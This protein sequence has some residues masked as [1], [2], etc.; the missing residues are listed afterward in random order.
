MPVSVPQPNLDF[1]ATEESYITGAVVEGQSAEVEV[2]LRNL[3]FEFDQAERVFEEKEKQL[4]KA[5][6]NL[7]DQEHS[8]QPTVYKNMFIDLDNQMEDLARERKAMEDSYV[9]K[10]SILK[11]TPST[12]NLSIAGSPSSPRSPRRKS[13][14]TSHVLAHVA[15]TS[16]SL[17]LILTLLL[18]T[19]LSTFAQCESQSL[20]IDITFNIPCTLSSTFYTP[21]YISSNL[22]FLPTFRTINS[23]TSS[24]CPSTL[25]QCS[26]T[27]PYNCCTSTPTVIPST[28]LLNPP[29][30]VL[31]LND[32]YSNTGS[33]HSLIPLN[34]GRASKYSTLNYNNSYDLQPFPPPPSGYKPSDFVADDV[35][36]GNT[37]GGIQC[38]PLGFVVG[39]PDV[40]EPRYMIEEDSQSR[41]IFEELRIAC[42]NYMGGGSGSI[43]PPPLNSSPTFSCTDAETRLW[44]QGQG[45]RNSIT[46][47]PPQLGFP[48]TRESNEG[49]MMG[50][51]KESVNSVDDYLNIDDSLFSRLDSL[52]V[53]WSGKVFYGWIRGESWY[54]SS[55]L[56]ASVNGVYVEGK[57]VQEKCGEGEC[58][59]EVEEEGEVGFSTVWERSFANV[60]NPEASLPFSAT[61]C[62]YTFGGPPSPGCAFTDPPNSSNYIYSPGFSQNRAT[63][64]LGYLAQTYIRG[65]IGNS[66]S[67]LCMDAISSLPCD[68]TTY[69][70]PCLGSSAVAP[71]KVRPRKG[72]SE[73]DSPFCKCSSSSEE[74]HRT[75]PTTYYASTSTPSIP[76]DEIFSVFS[77]TSNP[78]FEEK[79]TDGGC[80]KAEGGEDLWQLGKVFGECDGGTET[81]VVYGCRQAVISTTEEDEDGQCLPPLTDWEFDVRVCNPDLD[82]TC[83]VDEDDGECWEVKFNDVCL[84]SSKEL[85]DEEI[86]PSFFTRDDWESAGF[87]CQ[88]LLWESLPNSVCPFEC[89]GDGCPSG[90]DGQQAGVSAFYVDGIWTC[91]SNNPQKVENSSNGGTQAFSTQCL[92]KGPPNTVSVQGKCVPPPTPDTPTCTTVLYPDSASPPE[93]C[94]LSNGPP[95]FQQRNL[96]D[97]IDMSVCSYDQIREY[98]PGNF[99]GCVKNEGSTSL[100]SFWTCSVNS[101]ATPSGGD[102]STILTM[103]PFFVNRIKLLSAGYNEIDPSTWLIAVQAL[104]CMQGFVDGTFGEVLRSDLPNH[105]ADVRT[106]TCVPITPSVSACDPSA[107]DSEPN[108]CKPSPASLGCGS[109]LK[110]GLTQTVLESEQSKFQGELRPVKIS[111]AQEFV[112]NTDPF[113]FNRAYEEG[114]APVPL[115]TAMVK[116]YCAGNDEITRAGPSDVAL[117]TRIF[118]SESQKDLFC[119]DGA[120][121]SDTVE[122][123]ALNGSNSSC[124]Y[125]AFVSAGNNLTSSSKGSD[126]R[127]RLGVIDSLAEMKKND[128]EELMKIHD[129]K[130]GA[131]RAGEGGGARS[132]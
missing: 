90:C 15:S 130:L 114:K 87:T 50:V 16:S 39:V 58:G 37:L 1:Y 63:L 8:L 60:F 73:F 106:G 32:G 100:S 82:P 20:F 68:S 103:N 102:G 105:L 10:K 119:C 80:D 101:P 6:T 47:I 41:E 13:Q 76:V 25:P 14:M 98:F 54:D 23:S 57:C 46:G 66:I 22:H 124:D 3:D 48:L 72:T 19:P 95:D 71:K 24:T 93:N 112:P 30:L 122:F 116:E 51:V 61:F 64:L 74:C 53:G 11:A 9:T 55:D 62:G 89:E 79:Y 69:V 84:G 131:L 132:I 123:C 99:N 111:G 127:R 115:R 92:T 125:S 28:W 12:A 118:G 33:E 49:Q 38:S 85:A 31:P 77:I 75:K 108:S 83:A 43:F 104:K 2:S 35:S 67:T 29:N 117:V 34:S 59:V 4:E 129:E 18:L 27:S 21:D 128:L 70:D 86:A 109:C 52:P 107:S 40:V 17:I 88:S 96:E 113:N 121:Q 94:I 78:S 91:A 26:P 97:C 44:V 126:N 81:E 36:L 65:Y 5:Y 42:N 56:S 110:I 45:M 120:C 7:T